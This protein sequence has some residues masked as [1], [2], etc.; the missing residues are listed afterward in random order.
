MTNKKKELNEE[1]LK[2]VS[3]GYEVSEDGVYHFSMGD[4]F[5]RNG[6]N[7]EHGESESEHLYRVLV[8]TITTI[9]GQVLCE[10]STVG[11]DG[12]PHVESS[13]YETVN[14]LVN[15]CIKQH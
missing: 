12:V 8:D 14:F 13:G 3:G 15:S 4:T 9:K 1:E 10:L 6:G 2:K 5:R 11:D 7:G